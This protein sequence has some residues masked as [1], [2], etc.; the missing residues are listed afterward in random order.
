VLEQDRISHRTLKEQSSLAE[1]E[2]CSRSA[3]LAS[4]SDS[5]DV[6][7]AAGMP[8]APVA[9]TLLAVVDL[10]ELDTELAAVELDTGP[11]AA[12][13]GPAAV[14]HTE[15]AVA[16]VAAVVVVVVVAADVAV[17]AAGCSAGLDSMNAAALHYLKM[18]LEPP[19]ASA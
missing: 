18:M 4:G 11:A 9:D 10:A 12:D 6:A 15:P 17:A 3:G 1:N 2:G 7:L 5:L 16:A 13:T 8:L 14:A 19:A